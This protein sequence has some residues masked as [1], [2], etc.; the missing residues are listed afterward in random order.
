MRVD[1]QIIRLDPFIVQIS[2]NGREFRVIGV[3]MDL[4]YKPKR[5]NGIE[6]FCWIVI[7]KFL[8]NDQRVKLHFDFSDQCVRKEKFISRLAG[9]EPSSNQE[10]MF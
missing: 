10:I 3:L 2:P 7:V 8:D 6:K 1:N 9:T 5:M 4:S